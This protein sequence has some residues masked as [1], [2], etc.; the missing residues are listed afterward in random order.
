MATAPTIQ[1]PQPCPHCSGSGDV[2]AYWCPRRPMRLPR[3]GVYH[4][5]MP[6]LVDRLFE[7]LRAGQ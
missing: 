1:E 5:S 7:I 4:N 6:A 2:H 3:L